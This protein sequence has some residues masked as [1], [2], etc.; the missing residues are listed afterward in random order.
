MIANSS[1]PKKL[2]IEL[3]SHDLFEILMNG[4]VTRNRY[5]DHIQESEFDIIT[6]YCDHPEDA[7]LKYD[8]QKPFE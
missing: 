5:D 6:I 2:T 1:R 3:S 8:R 7:R 4:S